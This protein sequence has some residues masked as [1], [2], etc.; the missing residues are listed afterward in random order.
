LTSWE[1]GI[2]SV[3]EQMQIQILPLPLA[4]YVI[5]NKSLHLHGPL[6][7]HFLNE[8]NHVFLTGGREEEIK[9]RRKERKEGRGRKEGRKVVPGS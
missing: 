4:I 3:L 6:S 9:T 2:N 5:L 1:T 8:D 7:P